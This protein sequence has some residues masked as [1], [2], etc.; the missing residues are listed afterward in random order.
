MTDIEKLVRDL[1]HPGVAL[2]FAALLGCLAVAFAASWLIGRRQGSESVWFGRA[3]VDG[4]LFPLLALG[5]TYAALQYF[6]PRQ[7]ASVLRI[8]IPVLI[9][10]AGIRFL[11]RVLTRV[12]PTS[13]MAR[14]IERLFSW[15]AWIAAVLWIVGLLPAVLDEMDSI[16]VVFGRTRVSPESAC[17]RS[18][19]RSSLRAP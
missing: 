17:S 18:F 14:L 19:R 6:A 9:S 1:G 7:P 10:L 4:L 12:F 13:G 8:A 16:N 3:T 5:L 2:E 15:L 11:A